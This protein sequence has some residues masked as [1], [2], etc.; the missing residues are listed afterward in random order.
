MNT[1]NKTELSQ[2]AS[3]DANA[4]PSVGPLFAAELTLPSMD[5]GAELQDATD[6]D[7]MAYSY[8]ALASPSLL[9]AQPQQQ[10]QVLLKSVHSQ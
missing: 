4:A 1:I 9:E 5:E 3:N 8:S 6:S 7:T 2:T 10:D